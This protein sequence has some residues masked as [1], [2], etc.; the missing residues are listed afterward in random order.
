MAK[1]KKK[2]NSMY[3]FLI[4]ILLILVIIILVVMINKSKITTNEEEVQTTIPSIENE[5]IA[6]N[7][8]IATAAGCWCQ[9]TTHE[10]WTNDCPCPAQ[11]MVNVKDEVQ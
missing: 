4:T 7:E 3:S 9:G 1:T 5:T 10:Y 2:N 8:T 6:N 11:E